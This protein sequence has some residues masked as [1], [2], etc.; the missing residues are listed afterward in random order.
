MTVRSPFRLPI[1]P[2]SLATLPSNVLPETMKFDDDVPSEI[3]FAP[4]GYLDRE[5]HS[6]ALEFHLVDQAGE[7]QLVRVGLY[8]TVE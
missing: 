5:L 7:R 2:P 3:R 4:G 6:Q 1:A 8:G